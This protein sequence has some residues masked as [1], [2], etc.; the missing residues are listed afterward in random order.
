MFIYLHFNLDFEEKCTYLDAVSNKLQLFDKEIQGDF[1]KLINSIEKDIRENSLKL[2]ND[3]IQISNRTRKIHEILEENQEFVQL[4]KELDELNISTG[5]LKKT[6]KKKREIVARMS[7]IKNN[8]AK[9]IP[10]KV[11]D[12]TMLEK[13]LYTTDTPIS[14]THKGGEDGWYVGEVDPYNNFKGMIW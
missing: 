2:T 14:L 11:N 8:V 1:S 6:E 12:L 9:N 4:R 5:F 3:D 7:E 13:L 10:L